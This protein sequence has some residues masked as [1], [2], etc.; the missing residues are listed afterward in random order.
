MGTSLRQ[1][2][3]AIGGGPLAPVKA[4]LSGVAN[5]VLLGDELDVLISH[6][7]MRDAGAG[8]GA[9]GFIVFAQ[10]TDMVAVAAGVAR[11]LAVESCGQ[12]TPCKFDGT[13]LAALL[14]RLARSDASAA[15]LGRIVDRIRVVDRGA[16]CY[17]ATQQ[18]TVL[19]S[20]LDRFRDEFD[21]HVT[22][23]APAAEPVLVAEL[24][25]IRADVAT[26]DERHRSKQSDWTYGGRPSGS[27]PAD[28]RSRYRTLRTPPA[29]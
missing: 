3:D 20:I 24:R 19:S 8:L 1:V 23:R 5:P 29:R 2:L 15:D 4:V 18:G 27:T 16:R 28:L 13:E 26:L 17:L 22:G 25:D 12:C 14:E 7:G 11:F 6:E 21:A 9:A 10:P